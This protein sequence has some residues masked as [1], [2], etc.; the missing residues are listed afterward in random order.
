MTD[1]DNLLTQNQAPAPRRDLSA[2]ILS[3]AK[4]AAP[5]NDSPSRRPWWAMGS[6]A[7]TGLIAALFLLQPTATTQ[8]E[9]EVI[10][11]TSGFSD[12]YAWVEDE[13]S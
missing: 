3:A 8:A 9:W 11:E 10:A 6:L 13:E 2:R 1:L 5:A 7:A 12:L 4:T